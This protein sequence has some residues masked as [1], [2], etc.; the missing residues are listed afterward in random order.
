[1]T[2]IKGKEII[3]M[4]CATLQLNPQYFVNNTLMFIIQDYC[5]I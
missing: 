4:H 3:I 1:M 5:L 2:A